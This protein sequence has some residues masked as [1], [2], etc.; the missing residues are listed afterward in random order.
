MRCFVS[1]VSV[2]VLLGIVAPGMWSARAQDA[3]PAVATPRVEGQTA[4][5]NGVELYY[6]AYGPDSG[7]PILLLHGAIGST[8]DWMGTI[9][10]LVEA[11]YRT[12]AFDARGRGRSTWDDTPITYEVMAADTLGLLDH[13]GI[14]KVDLVGWSDGAIVGLE[15]AIHHPERLNK[16]VA[17]GAIFTP[18]GAL[19]PEPSPELDAIFAKLAAD[20]Q[21]LS[22]EPERF[23]ELLA[24][25]AALSPVAPNYSE[26][27]LR[28]IS[29]PVLILDGAEEEMVTPDQPMRMAEL[30]PGAELVIMPDTGHF[31]P[32]EQPEEFARIVLEFLQA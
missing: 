32:F 22:P 28:S 26:E 27:Q 5:I 11:G 6:E 2:I 25:L 31:A 9:P 1:L 3:T 24:A 23:E 20:Y 17:Y 8:E 30:I 7:R 29:V 10:A 18:E 13:L 14:E 4:S 16:L 19:E 21:R 15:L 12:I